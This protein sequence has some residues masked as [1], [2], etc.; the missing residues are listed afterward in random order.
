VPPP[1]RP[2]LEREDGNHLSLTLLRRAT[3]TRGRGDPWMSLHCLDG[4]RRPPH[5]PTHVAVRSR[6]GQRHSPHPWPA[7]SWRN[8]SRRIAVA[9]AVASADS[10]G[11]SAG[12]PIR[13][14]AASARRLR[15]RWKGL[16][17]KGGAVPGSMP[18]FGCIGRPTTGRSEGW[19]QEG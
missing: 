9:T 18:A 5:P 6:C 13:T 8:G 16:A 12:G 2:A 11:S 10:A 3:A 17:L 19:F 15:R 7:E 14:G 4:W 1:A